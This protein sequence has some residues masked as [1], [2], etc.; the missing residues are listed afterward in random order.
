MPENLMERTDALV[1]E[2]GTKWTRILG[3]LSEEGFSKEDG[4]SLTVDTIRKRYKRWLEQR[5]ELKREPERKSQR[6]EEAVPRLKTSETKSALP[7]SPDKTIHTDDASVPVGELLE[8]FKGSLERRD[9]MLSEKL[10][11]DAYSRGTEERIVSMEAR[12]E[13]KLLKKIREEVTEL[14]QDQVDAELKTMVSPGGSFERELKT[15]IAKITEEQGSDDLGSLME[16]IEVSNKRPPG[17]GRGHKGGKTA[18]FSATMDEETYE[19]MKSLTGTFSGHLTAACQ[20]YL[21]ALESKK[22]TY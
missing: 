22:K 5:G 16:G 10:K 12:L 4:S 20:L 21:R 18:R 6:K 15:L 8:L 13:E 14:V 9:Q 1:K 17:P 7:K 11:N 2:Y 3:V 19:R